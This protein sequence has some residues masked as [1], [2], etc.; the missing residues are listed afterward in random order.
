[1]QSPLTLVIS[2]INMAGQIYNNNDLLWQDASLIEPL[3]RSWNM[4]RYWNLPA[5]SLKQGENILWVRVIAVHSQN[6]GIGQLLL[7]TANE[8]MPKYHT[9]WQQKR[10]LMFFNLVFSL[11][12]GLVAFLVWV[13]HRKDSVFGWFSLTSFAW[14]MVMSNVIMLNPPFGLTTLQIARISSF[15][16]FIYSVLSCFYAWRL[17]RQHFP[18]LEKALFI[19]SFFVFIAAIFIPNNLLTAFI[20]SSFFASLFILL[21]NFISYPF[22]AYRAKLLEPYLLSFVFIVFIIVSVHDTLVIMR[23]IQDVSWMPY[24]AP[25]S[26]LFIAIILAMRL[27]T[28][29]R[30][31]ERFNKTLEEK[32]TEAKN[33]LGIY[34]NTQHKLELE[35][36]RLQERINLAHDLH[37]SLGGS[38]V[39]SIAI[40]DQSNQNL[41]NPQ[42]LSMLKLLRSDLRQI[43]DSGSSSGVNTPDTPIIWAAAIRYRF[44]QIFDELDIES[45]W[46][47]PE[48]WQ[49]KPSHFECLTYLRV[50]EE[51]LTNILKHSRASHVCVSMYYPNAETLLIEIEDNGIGFD[52]ETTLCSNMSVGLRSMKVRLEKIQA[53]LSI[54]SKVGKS[55]V[56]IVKVYARD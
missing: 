18:R 51:A 47:F 10:V 44:E 48:I 37:D 46:H 13:F 25:L 33:E 52:V 2:H 20:T 26:T 27:A 55:S 14:V 24:T 36:A 11:T 45:T 23:T 29:I 3:S 53:K 40:V 19:L 31:I 39:R 5:S 9:F 16:F 17:A 38:L 35:N 1:M 30:R 43:I 56:K 6:S 12:L 34:L 54:Q 7:G 15:C 50:I 41:T 32:V 8:V 49:N 21:I 42:F 28:N 4:P 22:I